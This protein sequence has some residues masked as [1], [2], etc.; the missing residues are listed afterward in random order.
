LFLVVTLEHHTVARVE[1]RLEERHD[2]V[3]S[4]ELALDVR[5]DLL[6][7]MSLLLAAGVPVA[8]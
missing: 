4:D 2:R 1:Q 8:L 3:A 6:Q 7:A 5:R